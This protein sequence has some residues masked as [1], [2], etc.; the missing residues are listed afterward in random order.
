LGILLREIPK[1]PSL[2]P[3]G[4]PIGTEIE[5][6]LHT[7]HCCPA[8]HSVERKLNPVDHSVLR[9]PATAPCPE[10]VIA[11]EASPQRRGHFP[12]GNLVLINEHSFCF[13]PS[14]Q[15]VRTGFGCRTDYLVDAIKTTLS[16]LSGAGDFVLNIDPRPPSGFNPMVTINNIP[17][18]IIL[19]HFDR[20]TLPAACSHAF[21]V[22][23]NQT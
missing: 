22:V 4:A 10:Q 12:R 20:F 7:I 17:L 5:V 23:A 6:Y 14:P 8:A 1:P 2:E 15:S 11:T 19:N 3:V 9:D 18:T 16:H 21:G 13:H